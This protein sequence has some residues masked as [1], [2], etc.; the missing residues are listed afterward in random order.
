[1]LSTFPLAAALVYPPQ[2]KALDTDLPRL[3]FLKGLTQG[4]RVLHLIARLHYECAVPVVQCVW[5]VS[6]GS[7]FDSTGLSARQS[8]QPFS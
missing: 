8:V 1:M 4:T 5:C 7:V 6:L 2:G 3:Q